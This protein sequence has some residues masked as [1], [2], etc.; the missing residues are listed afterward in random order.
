LVR[1][2]VIVMAGATLALAAPAEAGE[3]S[4][5][6]ERCAHGE[7]LAGFSQNG[8]R[9]ALKHLPTEVVEYSDC[10]NQIRKAELAAAGGGGGE[11]GGGGSSN[12]AL[13]LTPSERQAVSRAHRHGAAP[14]K[15]DGHTIEPGVVH[16]NVASVTST[17]PS[18]L[19]AILALL[20][21]GALTLAGTEAYKRVRASRHR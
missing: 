5:I 21:A 2:T 4:K 14:V 8:Y 7:S 13:P 20:L 1:L 16:A 6:V 15:L 3:A 18:S 11:A 19:L 9:E 12:V 10:A 17:L